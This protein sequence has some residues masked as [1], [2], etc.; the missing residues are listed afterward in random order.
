MRQAKNTPI[1]HDQ[2]RSPPGAVVTGAR[3]ALREGR[4][5]RSP[6]YSLVGSVS[7]ADMAA[8]VNPT[9]QSRHPFSQ[10][11]TRADAQSVGEVIS[12]AGFMPRG[13]R[14]LSLRNA[15]D[16]GLDRIGDPVCK[17]HSSKPH[18]ARPAAATLGKLHPSVERVTENS[19][20]VFYL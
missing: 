16:A 10:G 12:L 14:S 1:G 18:L 2:E 3:A 13:F 5:T 9:G 15:A 20:R 17:P 19:N 11:D 8:L 4:R 6:L 7:P